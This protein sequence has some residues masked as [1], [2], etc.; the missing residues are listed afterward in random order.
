MG[1]NEHDSVRKSNLDK[2]VS[3]GDLIPIRVGGILLAH[4]QLEYKA[5]HVTARF[6]KVVIPDNLG[7]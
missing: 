7:T 2:G 6:F 4:G 5:Q 1:D 3:E